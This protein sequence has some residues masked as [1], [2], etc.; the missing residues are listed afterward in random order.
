M[1]SKIETVQ[2]LF[3]DSYSI[4]LSKL[5]EAIKRLDWP[6]DTILKLVDEEIITAKDRSIFVIHP[7]MLSMIL[8][9]VRSK[10]ISAGEDPE[11][12]SYFRFAESSTYY[13][14]WAYLSKIINNYK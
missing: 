13:A 8:E 6:G 5:K 7:K 2:E 1:L 4:H 9:D 10:I 11:Q 12:I 3:G 14:R